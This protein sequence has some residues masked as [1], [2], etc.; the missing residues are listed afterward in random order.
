MT[1]VV[2][3]TIMV[4]PATRSVPCATVQVR[5]G[6][7]K[8]RRTADNRPQS[9]PTRPDLHRA[10]AAAPFP[11]ELRLLALFRLPLSQSDAGAAAILVDEFDNS[12]SAHFVRRSINHTLSFLLGRFGRFASTCFFGGR[13]SADG[14]RGMR[15]SDLGEANTDDHLAKSTPAASNALGSPALAAG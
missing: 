9:K 12:A 10:R 5:L 8:I 2:I 15:R 13:R 11:R 4:Q 14:L 1:I 7:R 3:Y 6:M